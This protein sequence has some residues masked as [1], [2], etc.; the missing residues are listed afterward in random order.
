MKHLSLK[1]CEP[2]FN[3]LRGKRYL[4]K[5]SDPFKVFKLGNTTIYETSI[6]L[7]NLYGDCMQICGTKQNR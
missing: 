5:F 6:T 7:V 3:R 2:W 1:N 4:Y